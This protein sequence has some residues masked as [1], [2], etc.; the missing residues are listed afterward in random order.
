MSSTVR[1]CRRMP[2][3]APGRPGAQ[4]AARSA[5]GA[6]A[7]S[8]A[9]RIRLP[10]APATATEMRSADVASAPPAR[11]LSS[12]SPSGDAHARTRWPSTRAMARQ[13][14]VST[15]GSANHSAT[16]TRVLLRTVLGERERS[17]PAPPRTATA[18]SRAPYV[19][20]RASRHASGRASGHGQARRDEPVGE[21]AVRSPRPR[22]SARTGAI[23]D[24]PPGPIAPMTERSISS[25]PPGSTTVAQPVWARS[26]RR[27]RAMETSVRSATAPGRRTGTRPRTA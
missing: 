21:A 11:A 17:T 27:W 18:A 2:P 9:A 1:R 15:S 20:D 8:K 14:R 6:T 7:R 10:T 26:S 13:L 3:C 24:C 19:R 22:R 23:R 12:R 4:S 25:R 16:S 5:A